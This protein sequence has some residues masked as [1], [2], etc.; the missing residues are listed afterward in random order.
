MEGKRGKKKRKVFG[1]HYSHFLL[2]K[3]DRRSARCTAGLMVHSIVGGIVALFAG[4]VQVYWYFVYQRN[5][6]VIVMYS[7]YSRKAGRRSG[8]GPCTEK[9]V[10]AREHRQAP[11]VLNCF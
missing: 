10:S 3:V 6:V 4:I 9:H 2:A 11:R 1:V 7:V 5:A 8:V